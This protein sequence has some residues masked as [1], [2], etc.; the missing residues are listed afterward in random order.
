M[1]FGF[2]HTYRV[3]PFHLNQRNLSLRSISVGK[4]GFYYSQPLW[5]GKHSVTKG[6]RPVAP[7]SQPK[8]HALRNA[9]IVAAFLLVLILVLLIAL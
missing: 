8:G 7:S 2:R 4:K 5:N 6:S 1:G 3:G 9:W